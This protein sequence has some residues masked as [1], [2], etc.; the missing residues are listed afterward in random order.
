MVPKQPR[1][2]YADSACGAFDFASCDDQKLTIQNPFGKIN[3]TGRE[4]RRIKS[5]IARM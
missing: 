3:S 1:A 5:L 4:P 2:P